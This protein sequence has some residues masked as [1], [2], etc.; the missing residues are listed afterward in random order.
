VADV[1]SVAFGREAGKPQLLDDLCLVEPQEAR[2]A[3]DAQIFGKIGLHQAGAG[4]KQEA[5]S[6]GQLHELDC[7]AHRIDV[8]RD[9]VAEHQASLGA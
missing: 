7:V 3:P 4:R 1:A 8:P 6:P 2:F 5:V 9:H